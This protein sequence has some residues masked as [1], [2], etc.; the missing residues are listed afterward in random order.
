MGNVSLFYAN[1]TAQHVNVQ[2][3][4]TETVS[5]MLMLQAAG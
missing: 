3:L 4:E 1:I 2:L 5:L